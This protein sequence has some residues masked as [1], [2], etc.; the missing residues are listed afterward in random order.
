MRHVTITP[1]GQKRVLLVQSG[2]LGLALKQMADT[3]EN[4]AKAQVAAR[5]AETA[6]G[7]AIA[8][9]DDV[10]DGLDA[11][12]SRDASNISSGA[13]WRNAL[14]LGGASVL[15]VGATEDT[16]AA[17]DDPRLEAVGGK[18]DADLS[19]VGEDV[20]AGLSVLLP[21][22]PVARPLE[23]LLLA[24][25]VPV[26]LFGAK[27]DGVANDSAAF[28]AG[29]DWIA[30]RTGPARGGRLVLSSAVYR[31][32]GLVL[33]PGVT[34]VGQGEGASII[35]APDGANVD[36]LTV[37]A[38]FALGGFSDLTIDGNRQNNTTGSGLVFGATGS[39]DG[40]SFEPYKRKVFEPPHSYKHF[41]A[42]RFHVGNCAE[43]GIK[44]NPSNFAI[45]LSNFTS[46]HNARHGF[47]NLAS[48]CI[49]SSFYIEKNGSA[50]L[51]ANG[52]NCKFVAGK[53]IWNCLTNATF[54]GLHEQGSGHS[55]VN[56]ESQDN[57]GHG[58]AILGINPIFLG[59]YSNTNGRLSP[60]TGDQS[61]ELYYDIVVGSSATGI[62]A[63]GKVGSY[64]TAQV[65]GKWIGQAAYWFN[66]FALAQVAVWDIVIDT[67]TRYNAKPNVTR[68][69]IVN[70]TLVALHATSSDGG[71]NVT[72]HVSPKGTVQSIFQFFR[73]SVAGLPALVQI[74]QPG[75]ANVRHQFNGETGDALLCQGGSGKVLIG[76]TIAADGWKTPVR[77]GGGHL[78]IS[79]AGKAMIKAGAAA[80]ASD[81]DGVVIGTQT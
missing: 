57:Y 69:Q 3:S 5:D 14:G 22:L 65:G 41:R 59:L 48:D 44:T 31:A 24:A 63:R 46:S 12:A 71:A 15:E 51:L 13:A 6:A 39:S 28:Q 40:D 26:E 36:V 1:N 73:E 23:F 11:K 64:Q 45:D 29:I 10:V 55:F 37:P 17:G 79:A 74:M 27:G 70:S 7:Q 34:L 60:E 50:G 49:Y 68:D 66:S 19:N 43:D 76:S 78:W 42:T 77:F 35:C 16:V 4:A 32:A 38:D 2:T 25:G 67:P 9:R 72:V 62:I 47:H 33:K 52:S 81:A 30:A 53:S 20:L 56:V 8:A 18:A 80:P 54:A 61:A 58:I 75:T 21:G